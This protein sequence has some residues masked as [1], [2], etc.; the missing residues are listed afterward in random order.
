MQLLREANMAIRAAIR[1]DLTRVDLT[2][3][4]RTALMFCDANPGSSSAELARLMHVTAQT[5][6]K[7]TA[8]LARRELLEMSPRPGHG[9]IL[10]VHLTESGKELLADANAVVAEVEDRMTAELGP[11]NRRQLLDML[12]RCITAI[13][14]PDAG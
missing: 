7:L 10:D 8:E 13:D 9:R 3:A 6:H 4:Q 5:M 12:Q 2:P 14:D 11:E 1:H